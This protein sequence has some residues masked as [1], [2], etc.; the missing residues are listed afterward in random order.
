MG[1]RQELAAEL[2]QL[3]RGG[4]VDEIYRWAHRHAEVIANALDC[5]SETEVVKGDARELPMAV[6]TAWPGDS[7]IRPIE[8]PKW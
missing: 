7:P 1:Y 8:R 6:N 3:M 2:R 5:Y 4:S